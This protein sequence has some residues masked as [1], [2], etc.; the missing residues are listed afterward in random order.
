[1]SYFPASFSSVFR[2]VFCDFW[3]SMVS[4]ILFIFF[5]FFS[6]VLISFLFSLSS[7]SKLFF[8]SIIP[9]FPNIVY[10]Q[11]C[12]EYRYYYNI[13]QEIAQ[14]YIYLIVMVQFF[15]IGFVW[16]IIWVPFL[17]P[18]NPPM[19]D[20]HRGTL[21]CYCCLRGSVHTYGLQLLR[22]LAGRPAAPVGSRRSCLDAVSVEPAAV[23]KGKGAVGVF[24]IGAECFDFVRGGRKKPE[25]P[26]EIRWGI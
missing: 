17:N 14:L 11:Y 2:R 4:F 9:P 7:S 23:A 10:K 3:L 22:T 19:P 16:F 21:A 1:M 24:Y 26:D 20:S 18:L 15:I 6:V 25:I 12:F 5:A 8:F 13:I